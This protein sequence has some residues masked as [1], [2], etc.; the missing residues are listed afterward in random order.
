M[1]KTKI[2]ISQVTN[3]TDARYF[4]AMGADFLGFTIHPDH[5]QFVSPPQLKE[6][7]DWVEGPETVLE[8]PDVIDDLWLSNYRN[9]L[10]DYYLESPISNFYPDFHVLSSLDMNIADKECFIIYQ[11]ATPWKAQ[12]DIISY[13]CSK[14][15]DRIFLDVPFEV[16]E[17]E[18]LLSLN[19]YGMILRGG[20]EEKTGYKSY[21]DLDEVFEFLMP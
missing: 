1:L 16:K 18:S 8:I 20:E 12:Q 10:E 21:N 19:P 14:Y 4:A 5:P 2:K 9:L 7:M 6:I 3:L 13:L 15:K 17:L 11:S